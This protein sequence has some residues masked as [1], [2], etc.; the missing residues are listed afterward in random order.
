MPEFALVSRPAL[1]HSP[2]G[3]ASRVRIEALPEGHV[4]HVLAAGGRDITPE[5]L[6]SLG[7]GT[8]HAVR[9][10]AP[11][12]WFVVGNEALGSKEYR[13]KAAR[14]GADAAVSDQSHG[15]VR[16]AVSGSGARSLLAK[17]CAV[18]F[19]PSVFAVG[20]TAATL[21]NHI[22]IHV[23]RTAEDGFE[24]LVLRS[25]AQSLWEDLSVNHGE[26]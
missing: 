17:G 11:G 5:Q 1:P 19:S 3:D 18:D 26:H 23:T 14:L 12:Q 13:E 25:F 22:G 6:A 10:Y 4:L 8:A 9:R 24:L 2:V 20:A 15:R 16:V 7:D 21:Y